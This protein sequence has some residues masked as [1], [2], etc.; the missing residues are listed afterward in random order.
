MLTPNMGPTA[1]ER[2]KG[3]EPSSS[4]WEAEVMPLYDA[5]MPDAVTYI[6]DFTAFRPWRTN[7]PRV[8]SL[9]GLV[10]EN[11]CAGQNP[12]HQYLI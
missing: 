9:H 4:A 10:G 12:T 8:V 5:R 2:A 6:S 7:H 11:H 1:M 3:V